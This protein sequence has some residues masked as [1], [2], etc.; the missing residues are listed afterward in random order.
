MW[1]PAAQQVSV[2]SPEVSVQ[3]RVQD[4]VQSRVEVTQPEHYRMCESVWLSLM[5]QT[6]ACEEDDIWKPTDDE[7]SKY[8]GKCHGGFVFPK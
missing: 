2:G 5:F 4:G 3:G 8:S 7:D 6:H 1:V